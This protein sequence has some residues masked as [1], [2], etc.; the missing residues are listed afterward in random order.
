MAGGAQEGRGFWSKD[1]STTQEGDKRPEKS[2][3]H[4]TTQEQQ[5]L[6]DE[7]AGGPPQNNGGLLGRAY[8]A[9]DFGRGPGHNDPDPALRG[10]CPRYNLR[11]G[12]QVGVGWEMGNFGS[13]GLGWILTP[14]ASLADQCSPLRL[15]SACTWTTGSKE[16]GMNTIGLLGVDRH[17]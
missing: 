10:Q 13:G 8:P 5:S 4:H 7:C 17:N 2:T 16:E 15:R 11:E 6:P 9:A 14:G 12:A 3:E 1:P